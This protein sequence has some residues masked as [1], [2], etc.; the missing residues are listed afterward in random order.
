MIDDPA[1]TP[2]QAVGHPQGPADVFGRDLLQAMAELY[3]LYVD[4]L[5]IMALGAAVLPRYP[6]ENAF[7]SPVTILQ[8]LNGPVAAFRAQRFPSASSLNIAFSSS[9]SAGTS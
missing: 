7:R 2:Q 6:T 9:A 8:N 4:N 3:L 1:I 5:A